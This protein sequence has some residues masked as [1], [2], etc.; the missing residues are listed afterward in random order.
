MLREAEV[1]LSQGQGIG[2]LCEGL[3]ALH[4]L[5]PLASGRTLGDIKFFAWANAFL[6]KWRSL[7]PSPSS[8]GPP[9]PFTSVN[10]A[11]AFQKSSAALRPVRPAWE[12][13]W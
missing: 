11:A 8:H 3:S 10:G 1:R 9:Q 5:Q 7:A 12:V 13:R 4:L 6:P 2:L